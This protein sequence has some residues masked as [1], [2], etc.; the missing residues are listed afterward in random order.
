MGK[1]RE[2]E[3]TIQVTPRV[4]DICS[5]MIEHFPYNKVRGHKDCTTFKD[6]FNL[7][8]TTKLTP[9]EVLTV[10][11]LLYGF[12]YAETVQDPSSMEGESLDEMLEEMYEDGEEKDI[13]YTKQILSSIYE[14]VSPVVEKLMDTKCDT[15][16]QVL[17][18]YEEA[19]KNEYISDVIL[20]IKNENSL[21]FEFKKVLTFILEE[22]DEDKCELEED[23]DYNEDFE[24][25]FGD[26]YYDDKDDD[27]DDEE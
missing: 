7:V 8:V 19:L 15:L 4:I 11:I 23:C 27:F 5:M 26:Y 17:D 12:L 20:E 9:N 6:A 16:R 21:A 14:I 1:K 25:D 18:A 3:K 10:K 24:Q 22:L 2:E 13:E